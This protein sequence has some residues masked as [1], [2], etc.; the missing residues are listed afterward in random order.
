MDLASGAKDGNAP[1]HPGAARFFTEA[2]VLKPAQKAALPV[3]VP[4]RKS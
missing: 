4:A 3:K 2:G 1:L